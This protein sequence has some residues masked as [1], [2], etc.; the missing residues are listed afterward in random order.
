MK[1]ALKESLIEFTQVSEMGTL[2]KKE[3]NHKLR[4]TAK[5][6]LKR[7]IRDSNH[8]GEV[9]GNMSCVCY[10]FISTF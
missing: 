7:M 5:A 4:R 2:S 10:V 3:H 9:H 8:F 6:E 1:N